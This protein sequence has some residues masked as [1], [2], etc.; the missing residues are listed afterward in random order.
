[1]VSPLALGGA[2]GTGAAFGIT[3]G[4]ILFDDLSLY[5]RSN[6]LIGRVGIPWYHLGGNHDL[7]YEAPDAARS[8][9]TYKRVFGAPTYAFHHGRALFVMLD[10]VAYLGADP[11]RPLGAGTYVGCIGERNLAFVANL[12]KETPR[13][14]LL[15]VAMH[16]PLVTDVSPGEPGRNTA[17]A[18]ALLD[19]LVGRPVLSI[20]GHTHT[21]EHH[22]L[23][24]REGT[25]HHHILT[26]V[27]GSWWSGP[28]GR[29]GIPAADSRD[30]TPNGFH[31][32]S[33]D[34]TAYTTRYRPAQG[35]ADETMRI[36]FESQLRGGAPE[37]FREQRPL[38]T[39]RSPIPLDAVSATDVVVNVFDGG[40]RTRVTLRVGEGAG[41]PMTRRRRLD[42][43]V[44][45]VFSR[46]GDQRKP[47]VKAEP[48]SH[49]WQARLPAG[50]GPGVHR[51]TVEG[52]DEYGRPIR[53][54]T[55]LEVSG[56]DGRR[57]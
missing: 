24:A 31:V 42:P 6:R 28:T 7:N 25:H 29:D 44:S 12:L 33:V 36:L 53:G 43:F 52:R 16:I 20:A 54:E 8:R 9:E 34:G 35:V 40:P 19:L 21:T 48:S 22:Y 41:V 38:R 39:L 55:V 15:V 18:E 4:D 45:E 57:G 26:A 47:W 37:V 3:T 17:D 49:I 46:Y 1:M 23:R 51:V 5:A 11:A 2:A 10:N 14:T 50:L 32:L 27:S 30:G 56:E 13:E